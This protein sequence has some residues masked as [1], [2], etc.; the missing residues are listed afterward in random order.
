MSP[1]RVE[2]GRLGETIYHFEVAGVDSFQIVPPE[3]FDFVSASD[4][5]LQELGIPKRPEDPDL[6]AAWNAR[7]SKA[8][9]TAPGLCAPDAGLPT[10]T[11][12][13]TGNW[14][15]VG[16][17]NYAGHPYLGAEADNRVFTVRSG[18]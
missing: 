9:A 10:A 13:Q 5:D 15:G 16:A 4:E 11:V 8:S 7:M 14:G 2:T 1:T 6:L 18:L 17:T 3:N 12:V